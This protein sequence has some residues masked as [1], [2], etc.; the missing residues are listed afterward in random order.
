M[1]TDGSAR[2]SGIWLCGHF[3]VKIDV[4]SLSHGHRWSYWDS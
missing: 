4:A 2:V 1:C 3:S